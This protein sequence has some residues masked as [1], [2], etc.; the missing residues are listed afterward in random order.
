VRTPRA[1]MPHKNA[2]ALRNL[3][4]PA[5]LAS[6][7]ALL[8][9]LLL[10]LSGWA[11]SL[12]A[13]NWDLSLM[14]VL[15][16]GGRLATLPA[17]WRLGLLAVH[18]AS[19]ALVLRVS[20]A[21]LGR[22]PLPRLTRRALFTVAVG[23]ALVDVAL[24]LLV[25]VSAL[26]REALGSVVLVLMLLL[27][28]LA[29]APLASM[30]RS[31]RWP[32]EPKAPVRVVIVGGGFAGLYAALGLDRVLGYSERLEL[33]VIDRKNYFLFPPLLPSVSVGAIETRQV[34]YPFRRLFEATNVR[35][36]KETVEHIDLERR[37]I[38]AKVDVDHDPESG[39]LRVRHDET[40]FDYLV[41]A[42]GSTTQTFGTPG[43]EHAFFMRELGDAI[44]LRNHIID[45][46]E[47]AAREPDRESARGPRASKWR[48]RC[49]I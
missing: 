6:S 47:T 30:W 20:L 32:N 3:S 37:V 1:P 45:C 34:T 29:G 40:P 49:A 42:P 13:V 25:P 24:W 33:T 44:A 12:F 9:G 15:D 21:L 10:F 14:V 27:G 17:A 36:K 19:L 18:A 5:K 46:F 2:Y 22:T 38:T 41:L 4:A 7:T 39:T 43:T 16:W 48:P 8:F 11:T 31:R 23:L 35:F 28:Y 26:A